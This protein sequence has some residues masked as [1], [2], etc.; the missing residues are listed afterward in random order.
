MPLYPRRRAPS[1]PS[2]AF[3][4]LSLLILL[5][6]AAVI[7]GSGGI[8]RLNDSGLLGQRDATTDS[9]PTSRLSE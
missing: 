7:V 3:I 5:T 6:S 9:P 8:E 4:G 1:P 2:F